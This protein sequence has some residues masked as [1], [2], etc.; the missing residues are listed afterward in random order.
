MYELDPDKL[1]ID[2]ENPFD[3]ATTYDLAEPESIEEVDFSTDSVTGAAMVEGEPQM[4]IVACEEHD[5][6]DTPT[7][8]VVKTELNNAQPCDV[9]CS[10]NALEMESKSE[11]DRNISIL[12][13]EA[14]ANTEIGK[15][16]IEGN[17][18]D[19]ALMNF[20]YAQKWKK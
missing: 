14:V 12:S 10:S 18:F 1:K 4:D 13:T 17:S 8:D 6:T 3:G 15:L 5:E 16:I 7:D 19:F 11:V 20:E 2:D 9:E